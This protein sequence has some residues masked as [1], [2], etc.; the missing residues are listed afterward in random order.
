MLL[1]TCINLDR[2]V[3]LQNL[4]LNK[5]IY[6]LKLKLSLISNNHVTVNTFS[7]KYDVYFFEPTEPHGFPHKSP[8]PVGI[9]G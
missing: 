7:V 4:K 3:R 8:D 1:P 9:T 2:Y 5:Y 6:N